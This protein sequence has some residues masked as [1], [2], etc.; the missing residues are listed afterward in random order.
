VLVVVWHGLIISELL[1]RHYYIYILFYNFIACLYRQFVI[2]TGCFP[3]I[4]F[5]YF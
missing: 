5:L 3:L 4:V 2:A 1:I